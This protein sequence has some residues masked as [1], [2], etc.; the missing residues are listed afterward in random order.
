[1]SNFINRHN[2]NDIYNSTMLSIDANMSP[3][4]LDR[5]RRIRT[6]WNFYEGFHWEEIPEF[7]KPQITENY[8]RPYVNKFVSFEFGKGFS[9]ESH[10]NMVKGIVNEEGDSSLQYLI[11]TWDDNS[12]ML[13]S[14]E[15]GQSK[16]IT[17]DGWVQVRYFSPEELEDPYG[18]YPNG[19]IRILVIPTSVVFPIYNVHDK[20][21]LEQVTIQY[22]IEKR[23]ESAIL[24]KSSLKKVV[25]KQVWT[26]KKV[27]IYEGGV[28]IAEF[29]NKYGVIPFVQIKNYPVAGRGEG[30]GDLDDLIPLN[31][32]L[33]MKKSDI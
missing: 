4:D 24:R 22:P 20:E 10:E 11:N 15:L 8:C 21:K 1:M 29:D 33:N 31:M 16:S 25:Y 5:L 17:G 9:I 23:E 14:V 6:A 12:Q 28:L 30:I 2:Y 32:E 13:F 27:E 19:R 7:D 18:E 26:S 3:E